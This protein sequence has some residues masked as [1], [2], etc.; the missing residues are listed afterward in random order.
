MVNDI[1]L[2][3]PLVSLVVWAGVLLDYFLI[4]IGRGGSD[5][6]H[7]VLPHAVTACL[8]VLGLGGVLFKVAGAPLTGSSESPDPAMI[9]VVRT[10]ILA[11]AIIVLVL[12]AKRWRRPE[13]LWI[14]YPLILFGA[15]K[16]LFEDLPRGT[17][18]TL[19]VGLVA[20]GL[21]LVLAS[22]FR[23]PSPVIGPGG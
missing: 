4:G 1:L 15:A 12:I 19:T 23:R 2:I 10:V 22:R 16:L 14:S 5:P 21:A 3:L 11:A 17:P 18:A 7:R 20:Y 13:F 9:A 6:R 8:A